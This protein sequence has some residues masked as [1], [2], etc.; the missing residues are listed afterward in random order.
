M[1]AVLKFVSALV[2]TCLAA[3]PLAA[4]QPAANQPAAAKEEV[5]PPMALSEFL[6]YLDTPGFF[7]DPNELYE[8]IRRTGIDFQLDDTTLA[9]ILD[10]ARRGKHSDAITARVI[11][12]LLR[13]CVGCRD[14]YFGA[15]NLPELLT[16]INRS[17]P[18]QVLIEEV[19][20][21]GTKDIPKTEETISR[22]RAVKAPPG[23][24]TMVV[25]DHELEMPTPSG[26]MRADLLR[27]ADFSP[28]A[29]PGYLNLKVDVQGFAELLFVNNALFYRP[30][31]DS[32]GK[33]VSSAGTVL[34][35]SYSAPSPA[36]PFKPTLQSVDRLDKKGGARSQLVKLG[37][38]IGKGSE[39][40]K[41]EF[42]PNLAAGRPGI[43][44]N[45]EESDRKTPHTY[46]IQIQ[47]IRPAD[48]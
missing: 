45:V 29:S 38:I 36:V 25:P 21:R 20:L 12:E 40:V 31:T 19:R 24:I 11:T 46:D 34:S 10:A 47:W 33:S 16:L 37:S 35:A 39:P 3:L 28:T 23:L 30:I 42:A 44:I 1:T 26:Y 17:L 13:A 9:R 15:V 5:L 18:P 48:K 43:R 27:T 8:A 41:I 22:L 6:G 14:R 4:Q 32:G 7:A 2:L